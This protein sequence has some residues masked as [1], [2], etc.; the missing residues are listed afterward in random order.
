MILELVQ[1]YVLLVMELAK[2]A[3]EQETLIVL[4]VIL[5]KEI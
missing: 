5:V 2:D 3:Q 1:N 4:N